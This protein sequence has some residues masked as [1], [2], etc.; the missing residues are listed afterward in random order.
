MNVLNAMEILTLLIVLIFIGIKRINFAKI[1]QRVGYSLFI[2]IH[3]L[4]VFIDNNVAVPSA[5]VC[6][7]SM[8]S[9]DSDIFRILML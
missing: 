1:I 6:L 8:I 7:G 9:V 4:N 2:Q 5:Q 3:V